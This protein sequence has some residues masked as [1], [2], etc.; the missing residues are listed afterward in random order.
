M[1][2][3]LWDN[4]KELF[5]K[6]NFIFIDKEFLLKGQ[7]HDL[8]NS[9]RIDI[10][11]YNKDTNRFV[12]FELK[13][14]DGKYKGLYQATRYRNYIKYHFAEVCLAA[15]KK[16]KEFL[17]H[18]DEVIKNNVE[19]IHIAKDFTQSIIN[20]AK[21]DDSLI[22]LIRYNWFGDDYLFL[23]YVHDAT[24]PTKPTGGTKKTAVVPVPPIQDV[25]QSDFWKRYYDKL[26]KTGRFPELQEHS[27]SP[28]FYTVAFFGKRGTRLRNYFNISNGGFGVG[29]HMG[30]KKAKPMFNFLEGQK[31]KIESNIGKLNWK[32][33]QNGSVIGLSHVIKPTVPTQ[34]EETLNWLVEYTVKFWD[35]FSEII[36]EYQE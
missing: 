34:I 9:G 25:K 35:V 13:R 11:A 8:G 12:I 36:K 18:F 20:E 7:V 22:T 23:D 28:H 1:R 26:K 24:L 2:D 31:D 33:Y 17:P 6:Y 16:C 5:Q 3:C 27:S 21:E 15:T 30:G 19:I 10:L 14:D 4:R 32:H 29:V